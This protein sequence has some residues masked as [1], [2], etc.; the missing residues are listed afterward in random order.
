MR[1][2]MVDIQS[3]TA[4]IRRGKK[5]EDRNHKAKIYVRTYY[6]ISKQ[7]LI[8]VSFMF[9]THKCCSI[10]ANTVDCYLA[11]YLRTLC[12]CCLPVPNNTLCLRKGPLTFLFSLISG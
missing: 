8:P 2:S 7:H 6:I 3:P 10:T 9:S 1:G 11:Q 12:K 4:E 5:E